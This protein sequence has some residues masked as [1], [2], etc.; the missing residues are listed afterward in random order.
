MADGRS[1]GFWVLMIIGALLLLM[2]VFGQAMSFIDYEFTVS[3]GLQE[4]VDVIG[5]MGV[6][7]NKAFGAAD[8]IIYLPLLLMGLVGL[9]IKK[10]WGIH[11]MVAALAITAYWPVVN[12]FILLFA[13]EAPGFHFSN[14]ASYCIVL[15][16]FSLYGIW[17]IWYLYKNRERIV[18]E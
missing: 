17:G 6:A 11:A 4:S 18:K 9:W 7:V 13:R 5:E 2:L 3:T 16:S 15:T 12:I 8:T 1:V 14:F 10:K